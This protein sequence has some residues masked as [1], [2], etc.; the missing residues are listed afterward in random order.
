MKVLI[1]NSPLFKKY[2]N[3]SDED[4]LPPLGLGYIATYLQKQ[5]IRVELMDTISDK[6]S[7]K[8]L[9]TKIQEIK[10]EF[11]AIN[12][13]STNY[14][15]VKELIVSIK[16]KTHIIIG[17]LSTKSLYPKIIE[18]DT[19]N[20]I[21]VVIGA[22]EL[23][24]ADIVNNEVKELPFKEVSKHRVFRIDSMSTYFVKDIS[25]MSLDSNFF[26]KSTHKKQL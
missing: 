26:L 7:F 11:L 16:T 2:Q 5:N 21:D 6:I 10:P 23:I 3:H 17:G 1:I 22:G 25:S 19:K 15:I 4:F 18:W 9:K 24:L 13:F 20:K 12:I 14:E 8:K